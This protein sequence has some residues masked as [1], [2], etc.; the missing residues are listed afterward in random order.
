MGPRQRHFS[1]TS[2]L[3][4]RYITTTFTANMS[5]YGAQMALLIVTLFT[6]LITLSLS[7]YHTSL[8]YGASTYYGGYSSE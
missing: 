8:Y 3:L 4:N 2:F 5:S 6:A 1:L 7:A